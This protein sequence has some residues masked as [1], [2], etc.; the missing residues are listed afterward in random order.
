MC[1]KLNSMKRLFTLLC[2]LGYVHSQAQPTT[3]TTGVPALTSM[4][5]TEPGVAFII[6]NT[7][8][9]PIVLKTIDV[10]TGSNQNGN[11]FYLKYSATS[12]SGPPTGGN[13]WPIVATA[14]QGTVSTTAIHPMFTNINF[15]IPANTTYRFLVHNSGSAWYYGGA[16][17][18]PN[19]FSNGGVLL[20]RG[21]YMIAS[22]VVGYAG[23]T[24]NYNA[25]N[26]R[27]WCG[28]I[29]FEPAIANNLSATRI[30]TPAN[31]SSVCANTPI[32][33]SVVI[34]NKGSASQS[35]FPVSAYYYG[36]G[37]AGTLT[38]VYSGTLAAGAVDTVSVGSITPAPSAYSVFGYTGLVADSVKNDDTSASVNFT[39]H[40]PVPLPTTISDTVCLGDTALL[41][42]TAPGSNPHFNWYTSL[43]NP[44]SFYVGDSYSIPS[45]SADTTFYVSITENNCE[46]ARIPVHGVIG[47]PPVVD[48][49]PDTGFCA[50]IPLILDAGN[51]GG[52][53][54]WSNGDTTQTISVTTQSGAYWVIVDKYCTSSDTINV[55]VRPM[56]YV[57]GISWIRMNNTYQFSASS[58]QD[59]ESY[60]WEFGD[61]A[62][63][64][65]SSPV[66][67]YATT[68]N[69]A[70]SVKL[71]VSNTCG[72]DTVYR[73]VPTSVGNL[74]WDEGIN[75]YPN[76]AA[77]RVFIDAP[78][79]R[80]SEVTIINTLGSLV[81]SQKTDGLSG[82]TQVDISHLAPGSYIL[83]LQTDSGP[84]S[85]PLQIR[86]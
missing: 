71:T 30:L 50:S 68:I 34:A 43:N 10:L 61:G 27:F 60:F 38:A 46:S 59:V 65:D 48:I 74:S 28:T 73:A 12:L 55:T 41:R 29:I 19:S 64:T 49:G 15:T 18:T 26:P 40:P 36:T 53:Y 5:S 82:A 23:G 14:V 47:T 7:N 56:P 35:N 80:V 52:R 16:T 76:P 79:V 45:L 62:T 33:V 13:L 58:V 2:L 8:S 70:L 32:D 11:T 85:R 63:S 57:S 86:R 69:V 44:S 3:I 67:T 22:Q 51:P 21:D 20:G 31:N 81:A 84:V 24:P 78:G 4:S 72:I 37:G 25:F 77:G 17:T 9:Y 54:L 83:R 66:H 42:L 1:A 75:I 6:S 39:V